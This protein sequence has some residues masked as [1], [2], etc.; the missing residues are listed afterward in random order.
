MLV[1]G[2]ISREILHEKKLFGEEIVPVLK[3]AKLGV[4]VAEVIRKVVISEQIFCG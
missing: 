4:P 3:Q 1:F 2:K